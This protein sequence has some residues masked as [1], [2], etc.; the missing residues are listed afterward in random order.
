VPAADA[1]LKEWDH[2]TVRG[3]RGL[4]ELAGKG[5]LHGTGT[6]QDPYVLE[7]V[8]V[9]RDLDIADTTA[10]LVLRDSIV[11]GQLKLNWLGQHVHVHHLRVADL[12]I[13]ENVKRTGDNTGGLLEDNAIAFIGQM[14]HF[15]GVFQGNQV[16][17]KP[18]DALE[19]FLGDASVE[20]LGKDEVWNLDGFDLADV[21]DNDVRGLVDI[22]LHGHYHG[23]CFLCL[24]HD[25][26]S[27]D[28]MHDHTDRWTSL[29]F[30]DNRIHV[31]QGTA[32][33]YRDTPHAADDRTAASEPDPELELPHVH[34]TL[35]RIERNQLD[36]P[37]E[38]KVFNSK[39]ERHLDGSEGFL[40]IVGN[41]IALP[42]A[43]GPLP[44][45]EAT[46]GMD[47]HD[48]RGVHLDLRDNSI[49]WVRRDTTALDP[50]LPARSD[51][52]RVGIVLDHWQGSALR[53]VGNAVQGAAT[54]LEARDFPAG[55]TWHLEGNAFEA[56]QPVDYDG[57]VKN[58]P[59]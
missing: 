20:T 8:R 27:N 50:L 46:W 25:H 37:L 4:A 40:D 15:A 14:R 48:A 58:A 23:D 36:G 57:S 43:P 28:T 49:A 32:L 5:V 47:L 52:G 16:G 38:V 21:H 41:R 54:G 13:N 42:S 1:Q 30:H 51:A 3:D 10:Y 11:Q 45:S 18:S 29:A 55:T 12:R 31:A 9:D 56:E 35:V 59:S 44:D 33:L 7:G 26:A 53:I 6:R 2:I 39:D 17:P 34:H 24:G 19:Q 22:K